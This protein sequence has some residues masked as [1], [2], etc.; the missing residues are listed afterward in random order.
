MSE[1]CQNFTLTQKMR[2]G[3]HLCSFL[4]TQETVSQPHYVEM[5][6]QGVMSSNNASSYPG[7]HPI[8][9]SSLVLGFSNLSLSA[10]KTL[11]HCHVLVIKLVLNLFLYILPWDPQGQY[12][13]NKLVNGLLPFELSVIRAPMSMFLN[14]GRFCVFK[15]VNVK[16]RLNMWYIIMA[17]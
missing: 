1:C 2:W 11:L 5:S 17:M 9:D 13:S 3:F 7:L 12:Q 8:E 16:S 6:S 4:P 14:Y 10:G 15:T